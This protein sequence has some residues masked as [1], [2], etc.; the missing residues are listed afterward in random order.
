MYLIGH[1]FG[2]IG[3]G[4]NV[5]ND[6]SLF[7]QDQETVEL[8]NGKI[9][10]VTT[11]Q[12]GTF[13]VGDA[14]FANFEDGTTS[15]DLESVNLDDVSALYIGENDN[16]TYIDGT[17]IETGNIRISGNT[18]TTTNDGLIFSPNS[19]YLDLANNPALIIARG[20]N[21]QRNDVEGEIRYNTDSN[22]FE[23]FSTGNLSFGGIYSSD[24]E[25]SVDVHPTNDS[26]VLTVDNV[27]IGTIDV[28]KVSIHG[29][30]VDDVL[31]DSNVVSSNTLD[32]DLILERGVTNESLIIDN[33][34]IKNNNIINTSNDIQ[35]LR[36][37]SS[38][39][40]KF[41]GEKGLVIPSG[42]DIDRPANPPDGMMRYNTSSGQLEVYDTISW[43]SATGAGG[44]V[45][46]A[47]I[48]DLL[49]LY[50]L[51]LG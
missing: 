27:E 41:G 16:I 46:E 44:G 10:Y 20:T 45:D 25:T 15:F 23:G 26:V 17:L 18:I 9:H 47:I 22:L 11:D 8:N 49:D 1:N 13:R 35:I 24:R 38:G 6:L 48:N 29:L 30:G 5:D 36:G 31:F 12:S 28:D 19:D 3:A 33:I 7:L 50:V 21:L 42:S 4:K 39:Y 34:I 14:F 43:Q 51:I 40:I 2:Y 37:D 32:T